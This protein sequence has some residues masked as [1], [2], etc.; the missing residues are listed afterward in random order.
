MPTG[1]PGVLKMESSKLAMFDRT[2]FFGLF[3]PGGGPEKG[4]TGLLCFKSEGWNLAI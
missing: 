4:L 1:E 2:C 3:S